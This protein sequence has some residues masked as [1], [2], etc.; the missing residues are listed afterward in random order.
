MPGGVAARQ[1][2]QQQTAACCGCEGARG[3]CEQGP[4][5]AARSRFSK[6]PPGSTQHPAFIKISS[7]ALGQGLFMKMRFSLHREKK[8]KT[9]TERK[10]QRR[11]WGLQ[12]LRGPGGLQTRTVPA[13]PR[14]GRAQFAPPSISSPGFPRASL[15]DASPFSHLF[16]FSFLFL[17]R[18]NYYFARLKDR[19]FDI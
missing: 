14:P 5:N 8:K 13:M 10:E 6:A 2:Q 18:K 15:S 16:F 3:G 4:A 11:G 17:H 9:G 12:S 19:Q 7:P 1:E